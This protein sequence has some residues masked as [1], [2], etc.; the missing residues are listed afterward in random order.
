MTTTNTLVRVLIA[1]VLCLGLAGNAAAGSTASKSDYEQALA[2]ANAAVEKAKSVGG[3]WRDTGKLIKK[4]KAA[5]GKG[6]YAQAVKFADKAKLHSDIGYQQAINE[7][8][9]GPRF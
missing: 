6:D 5:A 9:A 2:E 8:D 7:Q 4:A 1:A 3:E